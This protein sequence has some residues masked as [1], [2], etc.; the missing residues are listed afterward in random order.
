MHKH[1]HVYIYQFE[2]K[3]HPTYH[4]THICTMEYSLCT[5]ITG[6]AHKQ[7][8]LLLEQMLR[9]VYGHLPKGVKFLREKVQ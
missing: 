1:Q 6:P 2:M 9:T 7:N 4:G 5:D 8:K 3:N